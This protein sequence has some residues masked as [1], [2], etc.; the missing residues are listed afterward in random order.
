MAGMSTYPFKCDLCGGVTELAPTYGDFKCQH[1]GQVYVYDECHRIE[2]SEPQFQTLRDS[3]WI[4]VSERLP[5]EYE[6]VLVATDGSVSAGEIRLPDSE[7]GMD[8]PWWMVFKDKRDRS[9]AWAGLVALN[10]VTHWMP[11]PEPPEAK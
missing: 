7:C 8:E 3:R 5:E 11:L 10:D 6:T 2:L 1:C 9:A 4:P